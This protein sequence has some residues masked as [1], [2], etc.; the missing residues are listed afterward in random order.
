MYL[1]KTMIILN[2]SHRLSLMY[3]IENCPTFRLTRSEGYIIASDNCVRLVVK[4]LKSLRD[5]KLRVTY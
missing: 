2:I 3:R 1:H 4:K 5:E